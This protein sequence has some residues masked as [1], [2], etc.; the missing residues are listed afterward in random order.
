M[1]V[2]ELEAMPVAEW[3]LSDCALLLWVPGPHT[4]RR[5]AKVYK[6]RRLG[7]SEPASLHARIE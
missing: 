3:A 7:F 2:D 5:R 4:L 6:P 1:T